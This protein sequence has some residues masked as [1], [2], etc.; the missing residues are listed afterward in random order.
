MLILI[1]PLKISKE[2]GQK[3]HGMTNTLTDDTVINP[4]TLETHE[5]KDKESDKE[6]KYKD[7]YTCSS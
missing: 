6:G 2:K 1:L 4:K 3:I 7:P 5:K